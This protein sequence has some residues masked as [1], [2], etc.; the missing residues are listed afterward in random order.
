MSNFKGL[1]NNDVLNLLNPLIR[2]LISE[3]G[4]KKLTEPQI[5]AI[6]YILNG[7]NV[8]LMAPTGTG[9][10]EAAILPILNKITELKRERGIKLIYITPLRALNR[11][12]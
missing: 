1:T 4:F 11:D 9:K 8:L 10:T 6:P 7:K 5:R 3:R 12:L 2:K